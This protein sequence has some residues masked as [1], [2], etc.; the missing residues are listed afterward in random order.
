V[1]DNVI[2]STRSD[3]VLAHLQSMLKEVWDEYPAGTPVDSDAS[4][5]SLGVD[6]LTL[7]ILF[8]RVEREFALPPDLDDLPGA[9]SSLRAIA[10]VVSVAAVASVARP[11]H[12]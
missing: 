4:L 2:M 10:S 5:L 1:G 9:H 11:E 7:V 12:P 8:D 6:S 3:E